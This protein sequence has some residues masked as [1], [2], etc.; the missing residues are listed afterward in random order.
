M[1][2]EEIKIKLENMYTD[3]EDVDIEDISIEGT[4]EDVDDGDEKDDIDEEAEIDKIK[5]ALEKH[6]IKVD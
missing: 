3:S 4:I 6:G 5:K 1:K 2:I